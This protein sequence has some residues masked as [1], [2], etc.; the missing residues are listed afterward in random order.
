MA[1]LGNDEQPRGAT[2][3]IQAQGRP[4]PRWQAVFRLLRVQ[5]GLPWNVRRQF[6]ARVSATP[7][8]PIWLA[9]ICLGAGGCENRHTTGP[10]AWWHAS[11]GGKISQ[12][13]PPPPGDKDP[14][15][16]LATVPPKPAAADAATWNRMTAG[17]ITDRIKADEAAALAPIPSGAPA[18]PP[19]AGVA[20]RPADDQGATAALV[21]VTSGPPVAGPSVT[22]PPGARNTPGNPQ[23]AA[24]VGA[25]PVGASRVGASANPP[26]T[27]STAA[28]GAAVASAPAAPS[29][30]AAVPT[31]PS[32][33]PPPNPAG[34]VTVTEEAAYVANGPLPAIPTQEPPRPNI[35][36]GA[37]PPFV[38][39]T[40]TP[41][42]VAARIGTQV[43]FARR[44]TVLDDASLTNVKAIAAAR[45][46]RG[47][48]ITGYGDASS[49]DAL[50]QAAALDLGLKRAQALATALVARGVPYASLRLNAEAA[51][52]GATLRLLQ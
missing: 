36:P 4:V 48:A 18:P 23:T 2:A 16:N 43:D 51:G 25:S 6:V 31:A 30:G 1:F 17:L 32:A 46:D 11:V 45:G 8:T 22:T 40:A 13:R 35:A 24:P 42:L 39:V 52:R 33:I 28:R 12:E 3:F 41:P 21:G 44:S 15:P 27:A 19:Q 10:E 7:L 5:L 26:S 50:G 37:P 38:P 29:R 14:F 20:Q 47:I 49:S 34:P 9:I